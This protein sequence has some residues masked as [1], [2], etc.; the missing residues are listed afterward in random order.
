MP[1]D[2]PNSPTLNQQYASG[3]LLYEWNGTAWKLVRTIA[4]GAT[5]PQGA[6]GPTGAQGI[7]GVT[8]PQGATGATG[9]TGA[10]STVAGPQ[11]VT[12]PQGAQGG[13]GPTGPI[14]PQG[15]QGVTG[16]QGN[17]GPTGATGVRGFQGPTGPQGSTGPT[18]ATGVSGPQGSTG[19]TGST[20]A[21]GATGATGQQGQGITIAG[22]Y[23]N[24]AALQA[25]RPIG[26]AGESYLI[27]G[28]LYVWDT[29]T[30]SWLSVG[31]IQ[32]PTGATGA[33][34]T[35]TGPT[36]PIGIPGG[37]SYSVTNS[38]TSAY[39]VGGTSNPTLYVV[40]GNRYIFNINA[41]GHPF[42]LQTSI[43]SGGYIAGNVYSTGVTGN[44]T[45]SGTLVWDVPLDAPST[46]YY[47]CQFH[48][49][50]GGQIVI[51]NFGPTG[52]TGGTGPT[53]PAYYELTANTY[54]LSTTL[55]SADAF[56]LV[57][58]TSGSATNV[59]IE[60]DGYN[61]Y[62]FPIGTQ[63]VVAQYG[64]GQITFTG[65]VGVTINSEASKRKTSQ[66]YATAS[67]I[68]IAANEWLLA[69]SLTA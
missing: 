31:N 27:S 50:M 34:S 35:V 28:T 62:T 60:V 67:L 37:T 19:P 30:T 45:Q 66:Q 59:S 43:N 57:K 68:K 11:G 63:I 6:T 7:Q 15:I 12:G 20:G 55:S 49:A 8:G 41:T 51:S 10:A 64:T 48:G 40:R 69:G 21:T 56:K 14:G 44:G 47:V 13:Q 25:A 39:V 16:P 32:G 1:I 52:P 18:G 24:L 29:T 23:A 22:S 54:S 65:A 36:G 2:F 9:A 53:G 38:G 33:A 61:S 46:L 42:Y 58:I 5:G 3:A 17:A 4:V 26:T